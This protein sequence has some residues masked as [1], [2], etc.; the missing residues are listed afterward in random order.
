METIKVK[1]LIKRSR[2]YGHEF[3][4]SKRPHLMNL[5]NECRLPSR[6]KKKIGQESQ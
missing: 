3:S 2:T 5:K 4:H 6:E 1:N